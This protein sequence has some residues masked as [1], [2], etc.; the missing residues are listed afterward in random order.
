MDRYVGPCWLDHS[1]K[2]YISRPCVPKTRSMVCR[3]SSED[4]SLQDLLP[5]HRR[6]VKALLFAGLAAIPQFMNGVPLQTKSGQRP[7]VGAGCPELNFRQ[8]FTRSSLLAVMIRKAAMQT[9]ETW[10]GPTIFLPTY[11][12]QRCL[13]TQHG[14]ADQTRLS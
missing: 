13:S 6:L 9:Q 10:V 1:C 2:Y 8:A 11:S 12:S 14:L 5:A 7:P 3:I 4:S